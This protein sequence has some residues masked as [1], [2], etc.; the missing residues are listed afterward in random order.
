MCFAG[1]A[2]GGSHM[3]VTSG[4][5]RRGKDGLAMRSPCPVWTGACVG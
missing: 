2:W 4:D 3:T 5:E 1:C